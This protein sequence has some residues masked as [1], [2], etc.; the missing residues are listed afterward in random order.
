LSRTFDSVLGSEFP[1]GED[2]SSYLFQVVAPNGSF[3]LGQQ[4]RLT[5]EEVSDGETQQGHPQG[6]AVE[7]QPQEEVSDGQ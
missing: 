3:Q 7:A 1:H 2:E 6:Q 4:Y 5:V